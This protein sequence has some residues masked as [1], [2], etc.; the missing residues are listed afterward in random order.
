MK[1]SYY[2]KMI[3]FRTFEIKII[4]TI[5]S[6]FMIYN[7]FRRPKLKIVWFSVKTRYG[8]FN[9]DNISAIWANSRP[10]RGLWCNFLA[11]ILSPT[12]I[13][14]SLGK[15]LSQNRKFKGMREIND[16][17]ISLRIGTS[18]WPRSTYGPQVLP[19]PMLL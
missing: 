17:F 6:S 10:I 11:L 15:D 5:L 14:K 7:C 2:K 9:R 19:V 12:E 16:D 18:D 3:K 4:L 13:A 8:I 1:I